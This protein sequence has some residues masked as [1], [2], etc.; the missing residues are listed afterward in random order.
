VSE[1][2]AARLSLTRVNEVRIRTK[3]YESVISN[4]TRKWSHAP[5]RG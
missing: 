1:L 4:T 2:L 3:K 5:R